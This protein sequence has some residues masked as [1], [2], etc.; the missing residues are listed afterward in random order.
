[1]KTLFYTL[2]LLL[3]ISKISFSQNPIVGAIRWDG[4]VGDLNTD[5]VGAPTVGL[6]V[7]RSLG[8]NKYHFR[9]PFFG[10]EMGTDT[11]QAR[12]LTQTIMD[13][14]IAYAKYGGINYW[15]FVYYPDNSGLDTARKLYDGSVK[16]NDV[17]YC[18]ILGAAAQPSFTWLVSKFSEVNYQKVLNNRPLLYIFGGAGGYT[19]Q[20]INTIRNL[21][22]SAG[23]GTPYIVLMGTNSTSV[24]NALESIGADA[25]SAYVTFGGGGSPYSGLVFSEVNNWDSHK[26]TGKKVVPWV[27]SGWDPRPR[28]DNP[29]SWTTVGP[30][31]WIQTATAVEVANHLSDGLNWVGSYPSSAEANTVLMYAWNEF[32]EGG[33]ICPTLLDG[34]ERLDAIRNIISATTQNLA[35]N[36]TYA[37]SSNWDSNQTA[38]KAFDGVSAT[39]WQAANG[40]AFDG[41]WL[42]VNFGAATTFDSLRLSEYGDRTTGFRIEYSNDSISWATVFTGTTIGNSKIIN[43]SSITAKYARIYFTSGGSTPVIYEFEIYNTNSN[44][45]L[46]SAYTSST[47]KDVTQTG[48]RPGV[49][50]LYPNPVKQNLRFVYD[51][52]KEDEIFISLINSA[53]QQLQSK[54]IRVIKGRTFQMIDVSKLPAGVYF[55][56]VQGEKTVVKKIVINN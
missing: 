25:I 48:T 54:R 56:K 45:A 36:K 17:K 40:S 14:D 19:A 50:Q 46:N 47:N 10:V 11:V 2:F 22:T 31:D 35:R 44:L 26:A 5:G 24:S 9:L 8:P 18:Y 34:T 38:V 29:V 55:I 27:T 33:W 16:K 23:L 21:T 4:W 32:D 30:N 28:Y 51:S 53:G 39:N 49:V 43:F 7:E 13:Q 12:E 37:S 15:A 1:M 20:Q 6:Q 52:D 3:S 42:Q 41:Q